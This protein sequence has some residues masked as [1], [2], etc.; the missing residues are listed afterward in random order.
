MASCRSEQ[1]ARYAS[2]DFARVVYEGTHRVYE[3]VYEDTHP[4]TGR[5]R[6]LQ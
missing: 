2:S 6:R 5:D 3:K 1:L 4:L